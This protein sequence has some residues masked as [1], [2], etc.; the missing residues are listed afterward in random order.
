[1]HSENLG[2]L[3]TPANAA[4]PI[5]TRVRSIS[6]CPNKGMPVSGIFHVLINET[7]HGGCTKTM[8]QSTSKWTLGEKSLA[9]PGN[10]TG[11]TTVPGF[12]V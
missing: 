4:L 3:A 2:R 6:L 11:V 1:M 8:R 12:S 5:F 9:A 7:A 10:R